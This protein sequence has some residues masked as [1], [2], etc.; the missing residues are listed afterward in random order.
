MQV[1][2]FSF[3]KIFIKDQ[4]HFMLVLGYLIFRKF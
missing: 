3:K 2:F 4:Q 1:T